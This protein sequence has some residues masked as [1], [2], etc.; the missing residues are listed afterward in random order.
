VFV[1][2]ALGPDSLSETGFVL[3]RP[4]L[5]LKSHD[6]IF[7]AGDVIEWKEQKQSSKA[8]THGALAAGNI[9]AFLTKG[10]LKPY[11]GSTEMI[12]LS[13]GK[14]SCWFKLCAFNASSRSECLYLGCVELG[15]GVYRRLVGNH[16]RHLVCE[17][18]QVQGSSYL[19]F[20]RR[21]RLLSGI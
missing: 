7:A 4:T 12:V 5:Q 6:D 9:L 19:V 3:V 14:V 18:R 2:A 17:S 8:S 11:K 13:N 21:T 16:S 10:K 20:Q 15:P 1:S